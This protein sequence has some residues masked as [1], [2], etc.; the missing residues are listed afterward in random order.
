MLQ[1]VMAS[2]VSSSLKCFHSRSKPLSTMVEQRS[3]TVG[4]HTM[5]VLGGLFIEYLNIHTFWGYS[6]LGFRIFVLALLDSDM[7]ASLKL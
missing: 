2:D 6:S 3:T 1:C 5:V 4:L 7:F